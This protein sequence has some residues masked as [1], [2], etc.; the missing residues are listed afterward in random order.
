LVTSAKLEGDKYYKYL[1]KEEKEYYTP[2]LPFWF[3][4]VGV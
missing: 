3:V 1:L 4:L 2:T